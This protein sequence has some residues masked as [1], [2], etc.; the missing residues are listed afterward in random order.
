MSETYFLSLGSMSQ[1]HHQFFKKSLH[2]YFILE[3]CAY[4]NMCICEYSYQ[5]SQE[6][7]GLDPLELELQA[8]IDG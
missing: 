6:G 7:R 1:K 5:Q 4:V 2:I 8:I 3:M